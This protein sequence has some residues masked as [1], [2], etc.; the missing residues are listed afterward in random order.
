MEG[1]SAPDLPVTH[2][3]DTRDARDDLH[4]LTYDNIK[5]VTLI[6]NYL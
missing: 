3:L 4:D 2:A 6:R 5:P 1:D